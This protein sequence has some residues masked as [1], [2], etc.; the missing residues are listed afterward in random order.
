MAQ[1]KPL[2]PDGSSSAEE[3]LKPG[4]E[5]IEDPSLSPGSVEASVVVARALKVKGS[6][7][8]ALAGLGLPPDIVSLVEQVAKAATIEHLAAVLVTAMKAADLAGLRKG[9]WTLEDPSKKPRA[10][11]VGRSLSDFGMLT[12]HPSPDMSPMELFQHIE[13]NGPQHLCPV[14]KSHLEKLKKAT[15]GSRVSAQASS[16]FVGKRKT[17]LDYLISRGLA[18]TKGRGHCLSDK[19]E[20]VF[21]HWPHWS[22]DP[23][24]PDTDYAS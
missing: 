15:K 22:S 11:I 13:K 7:T 12:S 14:A 6:P 9:V 24:A 17:L 3:P 21:K 10:S 2:E 16:Y 5:R 1:I 20:V 23:T 4:G 8:K 19:G 18:D